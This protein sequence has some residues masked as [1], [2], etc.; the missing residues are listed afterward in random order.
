MPQDQDSYE[1]EDYL[2]VKFEQPIIPT[3]LLI[4]ETF[5]PGAVVRIW[6]GRLQGIWSLLYQGLSCIPNKHE[7]NVFCPQIRIVPDLIE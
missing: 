2:I 1:S 3:K 7:A 4:Y 5:N 6:G